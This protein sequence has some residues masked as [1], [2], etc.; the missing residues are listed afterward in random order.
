[1][2]RRAATIAVAVAILIWPIFPPFLHM[3]NLHA[4]A[5]ALEWPWSSTCHRM[6]DRTLTVFGFMM[7]MCSR[8]MGLDVGFA[9]GLLIAAP[10]RGTKMMWIWIAIASALLFV[11]HATQERGL[12]PIWHV[13]RFGTGALLAYPI[14]VAL[15]TIVLRSSRDA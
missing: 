6:I 2:K 12:H 13:T 7:P 5:H 9:L 15:A 8:C 4:L 11:E 10:W 14:G 3:C 1:M